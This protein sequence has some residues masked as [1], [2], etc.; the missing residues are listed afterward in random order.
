MSATALILGVLLAPLVFGNGIIP[1][2]KS[3][4]VRGDIT[5]LAYTLQNNYSETTELTIKGFSDR[6]MRDEI[7]ITTLP[8]GPFR[9]APTA[10]RNIR[11]IIRNPPDQLYICSTAEAIG[12]LR[13]RVCGV[14][15]RYGER[16]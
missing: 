1:A 13:T 5:K 3:F 4:R 12:G 2:K 15:N 14:A 10:K 8:S 11:I 16:L 6:T 9:L 7:P